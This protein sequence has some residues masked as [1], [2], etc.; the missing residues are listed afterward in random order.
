ME[1]IEETFENNPK[2]F[3]KTDW[4]LNKKSYKHCIMKKTYKE[5]D[6]FEHHMV[7]KLP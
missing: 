4:S 3:V 1:C 7:F 6:C 2:A 5:Q